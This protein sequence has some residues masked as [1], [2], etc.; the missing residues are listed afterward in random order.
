MWITYIPYVLAL[1]L[2][3]NELAGCTLGME[4]SSDLLFLC[5]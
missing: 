1:K 2:S 5:Q 3:Q 4:E